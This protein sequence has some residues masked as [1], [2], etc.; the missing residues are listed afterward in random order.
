MIF[1]LYEATVPS[2]I[3]LLAA[4]QG[5]IDKAKA[6]DL[7]EEDIAGARL[8][9]DMAPFATQVK[10][11]VTHSLGAIEAVRNGSMSPDMSDAEQSLDGMKANLGAAENALRAV[12]KAEIDSFVGGETHFV[13]PPREID[14]PFTS[15]DFLLSFSQPNFYFH[16]TTAYAILRNLGID[17]GKLDYLGQVRVKT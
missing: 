1:S 5:W 17:V 6:S 10:W 14:L 3:Q 11:M 4:G 8:A 15:E 16:A 7:A 9:D 13:F 12:A 2:M